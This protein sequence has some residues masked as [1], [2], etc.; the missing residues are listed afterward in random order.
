MA[1]YKNRNKDE[2]RNAGS[3]RNLSRHN[4]D[5]AEDEKSGNKIYT[6]EVVANAGD[7]GIFEDEHYDILSRFVICQ[8]NSANR[9]PTNHQA[10][11]MY[12]LVKR[13]EHLWVTA[14]SVD[15]KGNNFVSSRRKDYMGN[16]NVGKADNPSIKTIPN[17]NKEYKVGERLN[18]KKMP[19]PL[20]IVTSSIFTS[21]FN[22]NVFAN[23][24]ANGP[25]EIVGNPDDSAKYTDEYW[26]RGSFPTSTTIADGHMFDPNGNHIASIGAND[27]AHIDPNT[28]LP[29]PGNGMNKAMQLK[30]LYPSMKQ[31]RAA[32]NPTQF[33]NKGI[34]D[35]Y[36]ATGVTSNNF[37]FILHYYIVHAA[38]GLCNDENRTT[39]NL[40]KNQAQRYQGNGVDLNGRANPPLIN[41]KGGF[42]G[43]NLLLDH[44]VYEDLNS[45]EEGDKQRTTT[46]ACM[47][48]IVASPNQFPTPK[49][50]AAGAIVYEPTYAVVAGQNNP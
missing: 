16:V 39:I 36:Y 19:Y 15:S 28:G 26:Q 49:T 17:M 31:Y 46:D 38:L 32:L 29:A 2:E 41:F 33:L 8:M 6:M 22:S 10:H 23:I 20:N 30:P 3:E 5:K 35:K 27:Q 42:M 45:G 7:P 12:H 4:Y 21:A 25:Q 40:L 47:P 13:P 11:K 34:A 14:E 37:H 48:L 50:R 24:Y 1:S 18:C 44:V 43:H 9:V